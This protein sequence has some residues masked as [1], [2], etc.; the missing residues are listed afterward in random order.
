[1]NIE[2]KIERF[3]DK[4]LNGSTIDKLGDTTYLT[5]GQIQ[6]SATR[7][8]ESFCRTNTSQFDYE[9]LIE[10]KRGTLD[11]PGYLIYYFDI[12]GDDRYI[13]CE[14]KVDIEYFSYDGE[15]STFANHGDTVL[16]VP[17]VEY[18]LIQ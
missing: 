3:C 18:E 16:Q 13:G 9:G 1:M 6:Y 12:I 4:L 17:S 5:L 10:V 2:K 11:S 7:M 15:D 8:I 14:I